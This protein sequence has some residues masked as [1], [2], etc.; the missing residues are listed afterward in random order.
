MQICSTT[1]SD[2]VN[3]WRPNK[4]S[5]LK[6]ISQFDRSLTA[7][8]QAISLLIQDC[9]PN[10]IMWIEIVLTVLLAGAT[11]LFLPYS[12][13][14]VV[15]V[16]FQR[17]IASSSSGLLVSSKPKQ[18]APVIIVGPSLSGKTTL[19]LALLHHQWAPVKPRTVMSAI[20]NEA[21]VKFES[22]SNNV[23]RS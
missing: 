8:H 12:I 22:G 3:N 15:I 11:V 2:K 20:M 19:F 14:V 9:N 5:I 6:F 4:Q 17:Y 7:H 13:V 21:V 10:I 18:D 23:W 1:F 16:L